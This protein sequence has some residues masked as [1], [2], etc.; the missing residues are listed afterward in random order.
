[1]GRANSYAAMLVQEPTLKT[2]STAEESTTLL[3]VLLFLS[4]EQLLLG[5]LAGAGA[6]A[7]LALAAA[8]L[9]AFF[10]AA[11]LAYEDPAC[12]T[13]LKRF[14]PTLHWGHL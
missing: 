1:M 14:F 9:F 2:L 4:L 10:C 7:L 11:R 3:P 13:T 6:L 8:A 5:Q 12:S